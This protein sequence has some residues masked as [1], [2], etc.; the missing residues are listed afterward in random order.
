[1]YSYIKS[2]PRKAI[3]IP[4]YKYSCLPLPCHTLQ[5]C[6]AASPRRLIEKVMICQWGS[7]R[8]TADTTLIYITCVMEDG[9]VS[10]E[11]SRSL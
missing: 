1:M 9:T 6:R 7:R 10:G 2:K 11:N 3:R 5:T 4:I 8:D